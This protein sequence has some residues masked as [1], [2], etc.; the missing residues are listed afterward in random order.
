MSHRYDDPL[1]LEVA[2]RHAANRPFTSEDFIK[3][4]DKKFTDVLHHTSTLQRGAA[5][6]AMLSI[7]RHLGSGVY[8]FVAEH[9]GDLYWRSGENAMSSRGDFNDIDNKV[10]KTLSALKS[11]YGFQREMEENL[12]GAKKTM[13]MAK[14][15]GRHY[16]QEHAK[17]PIYNK[18][19][20]HESK[21]AQ[22][23]GKMNFGAAV[24]HLEVI[25]PHVIH[26]EQ[27]S[28]PHWSQQTPEQRKYIDAHLGRMADNWK[29]MHSRDAAIE[30]LKSVGR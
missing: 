22:H 4:D 13:G 12:A 19:M 8:P 11:S 28:W 23:I 7:Y 20:E 3:M 18:I 10:S 29:R 27:D 9:V 14:E 21:A 6:D 30:Y 25:K 5:E 1:G 24:G 2:E 15:L 26:P 16:A 17:L